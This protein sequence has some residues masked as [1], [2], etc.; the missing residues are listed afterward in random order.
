MYVSIETDL[1][2][3]SEQDIVETALTTNLYECSEL[4]KRGK[5]DFKKSYQ[6]RKNLFR[7][8]NRSKI[9]FNPLRQYSCNILLDKQNSCSDL[10]LFLRHG[11]SEIVPKDGAFNK[12]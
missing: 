10:T 7:L 5:S 4:V 1:L 12:S 3:D 9:V 8:Y 6:Y 2:S 11:V